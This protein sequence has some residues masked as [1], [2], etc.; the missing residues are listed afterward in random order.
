MQYI[1]T[2]GIKRGTFIPKIF[3]KS[4]GE[5]L[6]LN[7][8]EMIYKNYPK[9]TIQKHVQIL[10]DNE[11]TYIDNTSEDILQLTKDFYFK[12]IEKKDIPSLDKT[13]MFNNNRLNI[14]EP[15]YL[16]YLK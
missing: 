12:Y 4:N 15:F 5:V 9:L 13:K 1:N 14:Y 6:K 10:K 2:Q 16:K 11:L 7:E 3:I 8:Y